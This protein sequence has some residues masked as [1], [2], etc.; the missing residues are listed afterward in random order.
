MTLPVDGYQ[1]KDISPKAYEHPA[2]RAATAA[3]GSV[4]ML[5]V[6]VRK[7]IELG[8]ERALRQ[9]YLG[10]SVRLGPNQLPE[11]WRLYEQVLVTLDMPDVYD[12]YI[13][14]DPTV[15]AMA[16]GS[17]K[18]I[19]VLNSGLVRLGHEES[20]KVVLAHEVAHILSD[21]VLYR[22]ALQILARLTPS[23]LPMLAGLPLMAVRMALGEWARA[24][25]LSCDRASAL[26]LRDPMPV[27]RTL[28]GM[29]AGTAADRL[30]LD[31]YLAQAAEYEEGGT[32]LDRLQRLF[33]DLGVT[34]A[35]PVRRAREVIDWV[36]AGDFDR[37]VG[38]EYARRG[39]PVDVRQHAD[40]G[41]AFYADRF[42]GIFRD[43]GDSLASATEQ[44]GDWARR[45]GKGPQDPSSDE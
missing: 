18:P 19:I 33:M 25:E 32:G 5:D 27:C 40:D 39:D 2:D 20:L 23:R 29:A 45:K 22:T 31:A 3:L 8:Y 44:L 42:Q 7:L 41:V 43:A 26:V 14:Q 37:I 15:N 36:R 16:I 35:L 28:M 4:P 38:G 9:A 13:T 30:D 11:V 10:G 21:H 17:G 34:H 24:T 1:L 6:V 12:L